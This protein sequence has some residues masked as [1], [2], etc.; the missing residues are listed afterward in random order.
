MVNIFA[1]GNALPENEAGE[2]IVGEDYKEG[3]S[4]TYLF[5]VPSTAQ[6]PAYTLYLR[7]GSGDINDGARQQPSDFDILAGL[8]W[9]DM[10][11][12]SI[13]VFDANVEALGAAGDPKRYLDLFEEGTVGDVYKPEKLIPVH[14]DNFFVEDPKIA[15]NPNLPAEFEQEA[16]GVEVPKVATLRYAGFNRVDI[17]DDAN[18]Q[19]EI[20]TAELEQVIEILCGQKLCPFVDPFGPDN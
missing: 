16:Q 13:A 8:P 9:L 1:P 6:S 3:G 20:D 11:I 2:P 15:S 12:Q 17:E 19:D 18:R 5:T 7:G 4:I 10:S 14:F